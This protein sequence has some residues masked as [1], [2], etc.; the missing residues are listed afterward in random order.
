MLEGLQP[1]YQKQMYSADKLNEL[2]T[3]FPSELS[4]RSS[5]G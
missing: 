3:E 2:G 5:A 1:Y 4:N